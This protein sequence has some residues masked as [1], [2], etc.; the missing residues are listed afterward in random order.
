MRIMLIIACIGHIICGIT[1]CMFAY[2]KNGRFDFANMK[3]EGKMK[4]VFSAMSLRQIE[5]GMMLG[6]VALFLA[7]FGYMTIADWMRD[8][9]TVVTGIMKGSAL[10]F[11]VLISAHHALCGATEW[12]YLK[13]G[14]SEDVLQGVTEFFKKTSF[15]AIAY[16][17]LLVYVITLFVMIVTGKTDLPGW[18]CAF[19]TLP[20]FLILAPTKIPAKGNIA[21][22]FMFLGLAILL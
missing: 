5:I 22:A 8:Y 1:D 7:S 21:N 6:V 3:D 11:V 2:S 9:G 20:A 4:H 12:F 14:M 17:G 13:F 15:V 10:F 19:N 18:A 16:V